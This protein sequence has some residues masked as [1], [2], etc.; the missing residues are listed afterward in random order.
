MFYAAQKR[1][2]SDEHWIEYRGSNVMPPA[3]LS[4]E[5]AVDNLLQLT[6]HTVN[7][8]IFASFMLSNYS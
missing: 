4:P 8:R 5:I 6:L 3:E 2:K 7:L 1:K